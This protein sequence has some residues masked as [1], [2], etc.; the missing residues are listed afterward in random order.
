MLH[1]GL[2]SE[3]INNLAYRLMLKR[4]K[5]NIC[6]PVLDQ[7]VNIFISLAKKYQDIPMLARTHG[8][9]AIPNTL[10]KEMI[11]FASR[12]N[13]QV[14][15]LD[16]LQLTGKVNGFVGNCIALVFAGP[17][18]DWISFSEHFVSS[19]G[20]EP[21]LIT[22]QINFAD[23]IIENFQA[24]ERINNVIVNIDTDIWRYISDDWFTLEIK[25]GEIGSST[26]PQKVNPVDFENSK[27]NAEIANGM[28][29]GL[30][31]QLAVSWWQRDLSGSTAH[32]NIGVGLAYSLLAYR[33]LLGG[34]KRI[35]ANEEIIQK[36]LNDNWNILGEAVQTLLRRQGHKDPYTTVASLTKGQKIDKKSW[37][38]WVSKL[39]QK[40]TMVKSLLKLTPETYLGNATIL[41]DL[42][43]QKIKVS[44]K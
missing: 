17:E 35:S 2:T 27:G 13:T 12:L 32:R 9:A 1:F 42:G 20:L 26:M 3:D 11:N 10:G 7:V 15:K 6:V 30:S 5:D 29:S 31:R 33:S 8:Q 37:R 40:T 36:A 16:S 28:F 23:D 21:T 43:I 39:P 44:R 38:T 4:A 18:V 41:V 22:T 34:L 25:K 24:F 19:L 14:R